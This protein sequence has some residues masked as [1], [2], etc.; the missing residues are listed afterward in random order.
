MNWIQEKLP[1]Y[2]GLKSRNFI[3]DAVA[4]LGGPDE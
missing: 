1:P 3:A 2:F 4:D